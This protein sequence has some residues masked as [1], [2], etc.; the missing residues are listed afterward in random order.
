MDQNVTTEQPKPPAVSLG[1]LLFQVSS[2]WRSGAL[3][4]ALRRTLWAS[5]VLL[6]L[7]TV[8]PAEPE[9]SLPTSPA[10]VHF[11]VPESPG[12][13]DPASAAAGAPPGITPL[14][15]KPEGAVGTP[16]QTSSAAVSDSAGTGMKLPEEKLEVAPSES[17][18][19][20]AVQLLS[21]NTPPLLEYAFAAAAAQAP[22]E[23]SLETPRQ[24]QAQ[25][26]PP[27]PQHSPFPLGFSL[28][29]QKQ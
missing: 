28:P 11:F 27:Q 29:S 1:N 22:R 12:T 17:S 21:S 25:P 8:G 5:I 15:G 3:K 16:S 6:R 24:A 14:D 18:A 13:A 9:S 20:T 10:A 19:V 2:V 4:P 23:F 7:R 26:P